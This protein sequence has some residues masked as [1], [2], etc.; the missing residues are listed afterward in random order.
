MSRT[1]TYSAPFRLYL[2]K[3]PATG[4]RRQI[5]DKGK[6]QELAEEIAR[7]TGAKLDAVLVRSRYVYVTETR[8]GGRVRRLNTKKTTETEARDWTT[9]RIRGGSRGEASKDLF[10]VAVD[11]WIAKKRQAR[12]VE[13][14]V[15][16]YASVAAFWTQ[17]LGDI[18]LSD[19]TEADVLDY[20]GRRESGEIG[21]DAEKKP[22]ERRRPS[23]RLLIKD[24]VLLKSFLK[25]ARATHLLEVFDDQSLKWTPEEHEPEALTHEQVTALLD[26]TRKNFKVSIKRKKFRPYEGEQEWTPPAH[27]Y[28]IVLTALHTLLR[29]KNV[30][31]LT[32]SMV[33]TDAGELRIPP[34]AMK[35]KRG[36]T[37][38]LSKT[39]RAYLDSLERGAPAALVFPGAMDNVKRSFRSAARRAGLAGLKFHVLRKTG[40]TILL[41]EG[42]P[43][44]TVQRIGGWKSPQVLL[45]SY[46]AATLRSKAKAAEVLDGLG[47]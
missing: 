7:R 38:P 9:A 6:A 28:G 44:A 39:L 36:I 46:A 16:D 1:P 10:R 4:A 45:R 35:T 23:T 41:D 12:R 42:I 32:W 17:A 11:A 43:L 27:L 24:K 47:G 19:L 15:S 21:R 2:V 13:K 20:F 25:D 3:D 14:T 26:A 8:G 5:S 37:I 40:A 22:E 29:F 33:H 34:G 31:G 30:V 18:R